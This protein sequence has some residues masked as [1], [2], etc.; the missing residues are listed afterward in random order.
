MNP[1]P[2]N[3][4]E[5]IKKSATIGTGVVLA[6]QLYGTP[7]I[8]GSD[9]LRFGLV[10]CG[11]RGT[12]AAADALIADPSV[13]LVALA[14]LFED[15]VHAALDRI[16]GRLK[17]HLNN[18]VTAVEK[19]MKNQVKVTPDHHFTGWN[20]HEKLCSLDELDYVITATPPVFR[21]HVVETALHH[22]KHLFIEK[23]V[24]VDPVGIRRMYAL[25][26]VAD[27]KG[28][29]VVAGTQRRYHSGYQEAL[30]R[31]QDGQIGEIVAAQAY[32]MADYFVGSNF[33]GGEQ[34]PTSKMEFQVRNWLLF[35]WGS[36][37]HIVEQHIHNMDVVNWFTGKIPQTAYGAGGRAVEFEPPRY[38]DRYSHFAVEYDY[39]DDLYCTSLCRQEPGTHPRV[40]ERIQGTKG[41]ALL[42]LRHQEITGS[43]PWQY[44]RGSDFVPEM[45]AEHKALIQSIRNNA[46]I[47]AIPE[48]TDSTLTMIAGRN[49]AYTGRLLQTEWVKQ[50]SQQNLTPETLTFG[51]IPVP[52]V[53]IP[54]KVKLV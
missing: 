42:D 5:F 6:S 49:S 18:D 9:K 46:P 10:G 24:A 34:L 23:P 53:P 3:R 15:R 20:N 44:Q 11:G 4:R 29:S 50:R 16:R 25:G 45:V 8:S 21:P 38:G 40:S 43:K 1:T 32:W 19:I 26:E 31:V 28:L 48:V 27:K 39:G 41:V 12:G 36:G 30:K 51:T 17:Q 33:R 47:N 13:E 52:E 7:H 54:G 2:L 35:I 37:D 22:D 14:D